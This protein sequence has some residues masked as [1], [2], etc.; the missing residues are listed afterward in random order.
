MP[1]VLSE[2]DQK[3]LTWFTNDNTRQ[4][5]V[6]IE[7]ARGRMR[8]LAPFRLEIGYPILAIAGA[9]GSGKSTLLAMA[10][11]A[12]HNAA[13]GFRPPS[14]KVNYYT[15][16][17]FFVQSAGE[18]GPEGIRIDYAF[19]H[20]R[21]R[22]REPGIAGQSRTKREGGKWNNYQGRVRRN[23]IY[24]GVQRVVPYYERSTH[25]SYRASFR[26]PGVAAADSA[27]IAELAGRILG[28][29]YDAFESLEH[30]RYTL[31]RVQSGALRYSGFNM[32]AGESAVFEILI[33]LF[34][35][36]PGCLLVIDEIELGLHERA[37][38][39]LIEVLKELCLERKCQVICTTHAYEILAAL[40]PEGR[41][42]IEAVGEDTRAFPGI[43]ADYACGRMGRSDPRKLDILVEDEVAEA[44]VQASLSLAQRE[45]VRIL[46]IGSHSSLQRVMA[47]RYLE[48]RRQCLCLPDG[49]R[50]STADSFCSGVANLC[51]GGHSA[52]AEQARIRDWAR[53]HLDFL[54]GAD[55]P[56]KWLFEQA[57]LQCVLAITLGDDRTP[58]GRWG[59]AS[60][61]PFAQI[62]ER[63][64]ALL[65]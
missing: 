21:W 43:S 39:R 38:K 48:G 11:C 42:F 58:A 2:I 62:A 54:P 27:R 3:N 47:A 26:P 5:L 55:W 59:V 51:D 34:A 41:V 9:N 6:A 19:R 61:A 14:R 65:I 35:A 7:L 57:V 64:D 1:Y 36:G 15:F 46:P 31:P 60:P 22:G 16:S 33:T 10:A 28:K 45:R 44:I 52:E 53:D 37:R 30:R 40:P 32:G 8:G 63:V 17:D 29:H 25:K 13:D 18:I 20:D 56:E 23:V 12:F 4:S 24:F 50:R 49:D